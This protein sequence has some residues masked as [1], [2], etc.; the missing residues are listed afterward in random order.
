MTLTFEEH[1]EAPG[2]RAARV[3][4]T[5]MDEAPRTG[6]K[7]YVTPGV[8][9]LLV[10]V[11]GAPRT[12]HE[13]RDA[14]GIAQVTA[15]ELVDEAEQRGYVE[16]RR[17][18]VDPWPTHRRRTDGGDAR[19]SV[20]LLTAKGKRLRRLRRGGSTTQTRPNSSTSVHNEGAET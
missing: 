12:V 4:R 3:A 16:R 14:L 15:S 19:I 11:E 6:G 1:D 10:Y 2:A 13:I 7:T 20:V 5:I 9:A 18:V 8:L 17:R